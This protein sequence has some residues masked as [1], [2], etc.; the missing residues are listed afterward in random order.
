[1]RAIASMW[2]LKLEQEETERMKQILKTEESLV[3]IS[4]EGC[5]KIHLHTADKDK[6]RQD[7]SSLGTILSWAED[8]IAEQTSRFIESPKTQI[9]HIMTDAAGSMTREQA[10]ALGI[11]LLTVTSRWRIFVFRKRISI[12]PGFLRP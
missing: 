8:D 7:L 4:G 5:L 12:L 2:S 11:T 1:M 10:Q 3:T 6:A 9:I